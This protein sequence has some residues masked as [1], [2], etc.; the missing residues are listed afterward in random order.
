ME[1][2]NLPVISDNLKLTEKIAKKFDASNSITLKLSKSKASVKHKKK[3]HKE[4]RM[5]VTLKFAKDEAEGFTNFCKL[6][7]PD[8]MNQDDFVKFLFYK[9]VQAL[10][11]DFAAKLEEFKQK[12]PEAFAKMQAEAEGSQPVEEGS[13][14]VA[15]DSPNQ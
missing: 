6:A 11:Q 15:N 3:G 14:T 7:K 4:G 5:K 8:N 10:Q 2:K 9:G 1:T 12:D 13:V